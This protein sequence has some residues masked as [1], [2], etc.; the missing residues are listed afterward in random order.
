MI[1]FGRT[2]RFRC[3]VVPALVAVC[4]ALLAGCGA[5]APATPVTAPPVVVT[6]GTPTPTGP[7]SQFVSGFPDGWGGGTLPAYDVG[8]DAG[9]HRTGDR[10]GSIRAT[11]AAGA[12]FGVMTQLVRSDDYRGRRVRLSGMVRVQGASAPTAGGGLW[13]RVDGA[14]AT[15]AL[16]NMSNRPITGSTDWV[17]AS[18]VVDVPS[19]AIGLTFGALF[20]GPGQLWVD[21]LRL[22]AVGTD[23]PV[24]AAAQP[25]DPWD[26]ATRTSIQGS[27]ARA[28]ATPVNLGFEGI[29]LDAAAVQWLAAHAVPFDRTTPD[30]ATTDLAPLGGMMG[31]A[32]LVALGEGTHGTR[33]FFQTKHRVLQYLV[34][35]LGF[36]AF[37][38]EASWPEA[39]AVNEYVL[40]GTGDPAVLLSNLYFW[41]WNTQEVLD[42][43]QWMRAYNATAAASRRVQFFGF[44]MQFVGAAMDSVTAF[45]A[46]VDAGRSASVASAYACLEPYRNHGEVPSQLN[47]G[48]TAS[49][50]DQRACTQSVAG[51]YDALATARA[52]YTA[53]S[54][55]VEYARAL[56]SARLVVQ[57]EDMSRQTL[58]NDQVAARDRYMAENVT[59]LLGQLPAGARMM[60]WAHNAHVSKRAGR[61]GGHLAAAYGKDYVAAGFAFGVGGFNA[62]TGLP[63]GSFGP[64]TGHVIR[65]VLPGSLEAYAT[66]TALPRFVVDM[67]TTAGA[68]AAAPFAGPIPMRLIGSVFAPSA[69]TSNTYDMTSF[70][71]D[72]DLLIYLASTT[73]SLLLPFRYR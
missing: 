53:S 42:M 64:L 32:R 21:D 10:S 7:A 66:A 33:E 65:D 30:G 22:E 71:G 13:L 24:T 2:G 45:V 9:I 72:Y 61:M 23:V 1:A 69:A 57:W 27:Y 3:S 50:A 4:S 70:P 38:I 12:S 60:L 15:I 46:R 6:P 48:S 54:S 28:H 49:A 43:V 36:T 18:I 35:Q 31:A 68:P 73:A 51:V 25:F 37:A 47:Y 5:D 59:W 17:P 56:Q 16:D 11:G 62:V 63:N 40:H 67:R 44:D 41:T 26:A 39:N 52:S 29:T 14:D 19:A 8:V 20:T 34:E 55:S 58:S